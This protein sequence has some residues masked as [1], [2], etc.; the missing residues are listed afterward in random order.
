MWHLS[1]DS[2]S[3]GGIR[4]GLW[5]RSM[6]HVRCR[7]LISL[8]APLP[9]VREQ[10]TDTLGLTP[11]D[12][13]H[14]DDGPLCGA[15]L[16]S[17]TLELCAECAPTGD[18]GTDVVIEAG[19]GL[20]VPYFGW[21]V[22]AITW[23]AAKL[24]LRDAS[25]RLRAGVEGTE[26]PGPAR[27]LPLLPPVAFTDEEAARLAALAAAAVLASFCGALLT[28]NSDAVTHAFHKSDQDLGLALAIA[29]A[30]VLVSLVVS[31]LSDRLGRRRLILAS[32]IG[33]CAANA[34]AAFAP[35]F[36]VFTASQLFTRAFVN[37]ILVVAGIAVVEEA[38]EG[39]RAF[40]ASMFAL[41]YGG[42]VVFSVVLLPLA[43]IGNNGWRVSFALSALAVVAVRSLARHL[44]ETQRFTRL[45][46]RTGK[47]GQIREIFDRTYRRRFVLLGLA[48]FLT[49]VF[50][51]PSSQLTNRYLR[52]S[53]GYSNSEVAVLRSVTAGAPGLIGVLLAGRLAETRGRRPVTIIGIGLASVFQMAFFLGGGLVLWIAPTVAIVAAACGGLALGTLDSEL[54]PTETRG[55]SNG[56][57]LVCAVAGS[58]AG[59]LLATHLEDLVGGLGPAIAL[60]GIAPLLAT[61]FVIPRLPETVTKQLDDISPSEI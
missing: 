39:A 20:S 16:A 40:A 44:R 4:S 33:A 57:I 14:P 41:A 60:C 59:L 25:A 2:M 58:A 38:P 34:V 13:A 50:S 12:D 45:T 21:F 42:G 51:A 5:R 6:P 35:S 36:E 8:R 56:F 32:L 22:T 18:G 24:A 31:L 26:M 37:A 48:A 15:A 55:S 9:A 43:D 17:E 30:G 19:S 28:Q 29:R 49:N 10:L 27:R 3:F 61:A 53:H 11:A 54:F 46:A 52:R 23:I 7:T 1:V 47:R